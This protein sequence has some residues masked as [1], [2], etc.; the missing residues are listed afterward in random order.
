MKKFTL[1][2]FKNFGLEMGLNNFKQA[3]WLAKF[4][5]EI[6]NILSE[7]AYYTLEFLNGS[8]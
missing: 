6:K 5:R 8:W 7:K 4:S 3:Q 2:G 1:F